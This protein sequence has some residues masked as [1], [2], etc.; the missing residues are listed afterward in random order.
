[1]VFSAIKEAWN[2]ESI[3]KPQAWGAAAFM[4][5]L[6]AGLTAGFERGA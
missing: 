4:D 5:K 1:M 2:F 3:K 6:I